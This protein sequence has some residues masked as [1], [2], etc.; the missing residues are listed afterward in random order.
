MGRLLQRG[1]AI[2]RPDLCGVRSSLARQAGF[3]VLWGASVSPE[4]GSAPFSLSLEMVGPTA[5][6]ALRGRLDEAAI[7]DLATLLAQV[8]DDG[9]S[10]LVVDL[11][12]LDILAPPG[13]AFLAEAARRL[14]ESGRELSIRS[15]APSIQALLLAQGLGDLI[16]DGESEPTAGETNEVRRGNDPRSM[17]ASVPPTPT[18]R[19][20]APPPPP[21][22]RRRPDRRHPAPGGRVGPGHGGRGRWGQCLPPPTR[23]ADDCG[24]QRPDRP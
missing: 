14:S 10:S 13:G 24:G 19:V 8:V 21:P 3:L 16:R 12:E 9:Y 15:P 2:R 23:T 5:V 17:T 11:A 20:T 4:D 1:P 22:D 18:G 6:I 7:D